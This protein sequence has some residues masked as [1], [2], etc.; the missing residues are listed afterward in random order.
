MFV[1]RVAQKKNLLYLL[2][3]LQQ[4]TTRIH[5]T[6]AG[7]VEEPGY[8]AECSQAIGRLPA[9]I[10]V[11]QAGAV[12]HAELGEIYRSHHLFVL[13]TFGE[14]FGHVIFESLLHGRPV[15]ISDKTPW[16]NLQQTGAGWAFELDKKDRFL[17]SIQSAGSW[18][19]QD[20]DVHA[21]AAWQYAHDYIKRGDLVNK[22][23]DLFS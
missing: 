7:P 15:L 16:K 11:S 13:P 17:S 21:K 4:I 20:F 6:I 10:T 18:N 5:L 3:L 23:V 12:P 8:W 9:H 1:S 14:N 2:L 22:Y 19:Q